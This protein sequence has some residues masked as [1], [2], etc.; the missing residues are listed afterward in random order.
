MKVTMFILDTILHYTFK[1]ETESLI[2]S[3]TVFSEYTYYICQEY[4]CFKKIAL[5]SSS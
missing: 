4:S 5:S 3:A 1:P 2:G